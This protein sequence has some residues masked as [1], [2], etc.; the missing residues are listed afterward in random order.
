FILARFE[1]S[2]HNT[3]RWMLVV[4]WLAL[5]SLTMTH[6]MTDYVF[7]AFLAIW[8]VVS[9]VARRARA[10]WTSPR[11][12]PTMGA[13]APRMRGILTAFAF[14]GL[15]FSVGYAFLLSGN[16]VWRYISSYFS[17]AFGELE[18]IL[19]GCGKVR[20]LFSAYG[21]QPA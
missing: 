15:L 11:P 7:V 14:S 6:H 21:A 13:A 19:S 1:A 10:S 8:T 18:H 4:A 9:L 2:E 20:Q 12:Y 3:Y 5:V 16:P 17:T